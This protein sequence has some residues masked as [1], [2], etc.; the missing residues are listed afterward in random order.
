VQRFSDAAWIVE[1]GYS[2]MQELQNA[3]PLL[4]VEFVELAVN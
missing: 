4:G 1:P 3:L 2:L